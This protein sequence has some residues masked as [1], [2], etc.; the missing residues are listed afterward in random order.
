[1]ICCFAKGE[2]IMNKKRLIVSILSV[3][4]IGCLTGCNDNSINSGSNGEGIGENS[5][6]YN[7]DT[8]NNLESNIKDMAD[9]NVQFISDYSTTIMEQLILLEALQITPKYFWIL[10]PW[11]EH[12]FVQYLTVHIT[13]RVVCQKILENSICRCFTMVMFTISPQMAELSKKHLTDRSF[14]LIQV[15]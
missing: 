5:T 13:H 12:R 3:L 15:L 11:K 1:M 8:S 9:N 14:I 4:L 6:Q 2:I 7:D 10:I